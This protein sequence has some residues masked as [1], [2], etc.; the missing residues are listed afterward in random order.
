MG[1]VGIRRFGQQLDGSVLLRRLCGQP[2]LALGD[3]LQHLPPGSAVAGD[4]ILVGSVLQ[5]LLDRD[6]ARFAA[7]ASRQGSIDDDVEGR[8]ER[9]PRTW[10]SLGIAA[11]ALAE[12]A[13]GRWPSRPDTGAHARSSRSA[14]RGVPPVIATQRSIATST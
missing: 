8:L 6:L 7:S 10:A 11:L 9:R 13:R 1:V 3:H 4:G 12:T 14:S 2:L 5:G